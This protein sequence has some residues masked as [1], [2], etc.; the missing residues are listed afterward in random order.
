MTYLGDPTWWMKQTETYRLAKEGNFHTELQE[1]SWWEEK[2]QQECRPEWGK[3]WPLHYP[4]NSLSLIDCPIY[5]WTAMGIPGITPI[6]EVM[7]ITRWLIKNIDNV[8][9]G[10]IGYMGVWKF[11]FT[12]I[13]DAMAFK[14][15]K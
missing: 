8:W 14:L 4:E 10:P 7:E 2:A 6:E 15:I 9:E 11:R 3:Y 1:L 12:V 5:C 13:S